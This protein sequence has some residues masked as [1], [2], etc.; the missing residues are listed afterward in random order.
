MVRNVMLV[1]LV[2]CVGQAQAQ[3]VIDEGRHHLG[4]AGQPEWRE[5]ADSAPEGRGLEVT[6]QGQANASESTLLVR[7]RDVKLDWDVRLNGKRI[8]RLH[9]MEAALVHALAVPPGTLRDGEN[10]LTIGPPAGVD[11]VVIEGLYLD[12]R[13][14][15]EALDRATLEVRVV[16]AERG[17]G[18]PCRITVVDDR[19]A[20]APLVVAPDSRLAARP[21]VV[22]TPDGLARIGL[23][24]GRYTGFATRGF[25]FSVDS[26]E[27][28][29]AAGVSA[30]V[31]LAIRREVETVGLVACDT[32]VHT[33]THSGHGDATIDERAVTLA[34]E[35][36]ELPIATDHD[37]LTTD[38]GE[39]AARMGV[40][41][42]FTPVVGDEVTTKAGHF[43]AFPLPA[44][45]APPDPNAP[46][47]PELLRAIRNAP[48]ERVVVLNHPR[49][50]HA[51]F[52]PFAP[53]QFNPASGTHRHGPLGVDA[54]EII[55]S[56]A[57]QSDPMRPVLDWMALRA[58]G[59]RATAVGASDSHDV[60]RFIVGQGRTYVACP[61]DDPAHVDV[62][63]AC[64]ALNAG[65][66]LVSLG[67]LARMRVD[68]RF[69]V[70]DLATGLGP[71][72][73]VE[74]DVSGPSWSR[75]D[76]VELY[77]NGVKV[78]EARVDLAPGAWKATVA[79][80]LPRPPQDVSLVAV[81]SGPGVTAPYWAIARPYQP[82][83]REW[84]PRVF[85][86]TNPI[87]LDGDG[88]GT[89][90][91][92]RA[93]AEAIVALVGTA[94]RA[95]V[96]ALRDHDEAVAIQ[97]AELCR[98]AGRDLRGTDYTDA[99]KDAPGPVRRGFA[100]L[101]ATGPFPA[102]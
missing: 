73:R 36:I 41:A 97:A 85:G 74:V 25:E 47:W 9:S 31:D 7:Q 34:G 3:S 93:Y 75:A 16:E 83:S 33:L 67:L 59:E 92:P 55:N 64:R 79:W 14:L 84:S 17:G 58:R 90:T 42:Y 2:A 13:P 4:T 18:L 69:A 80:D 48:G 1:M 45:A 6:F 37:H 46:S 32:H 30:V 66:A 19:G 29:L 70:G 91:S 10:R 22:Y 96:P 27:V 53:D 44:G 52:R 43:N 50:L 26:R 24:P 99:L 98:L 71:S 87:D 63:A 95:L 5:F 21:G 40:T 15:R 94:P 28:V 23:P 68:G 101:A 8:G 61:D 38:L 102:D 56:G 77:A 60:A 100:A 82:T 78:R 54:L 35:G 57:M 62:D 86:I 49:D 65:R 76:L 88:D 72:V 11:D 39:A 51:G 12:P 89:W 20:L 81:A